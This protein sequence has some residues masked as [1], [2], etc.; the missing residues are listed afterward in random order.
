M[1]DEAEIAAL[2]RRVTLLED[3][4]KG[5]KAVSRHLLRKASDNEALLL[6]VRAE[7]GELRKELGAVRSE[8][9]T[10]RA[11]LPGIIASAVTAIMR[12]EL[13]RRK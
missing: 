4:A 13:A 9:V 1:T 7:V 3:D 6:E 2:N 11:D 10:L 8:L 12:E 5:E